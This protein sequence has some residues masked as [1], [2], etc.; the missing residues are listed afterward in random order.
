MK[1]VVTIGLVCLGVL[2]PA[3]P[4]KFTISA[5]PKP[6]Q[7]VHYTATQELALEVTPDVPSDVPAGSASLLPTMKV[8]G[9]TN[10]AF[11]QTSGTPDPQGRTTALLTYEQ[12]SGEMSV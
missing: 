1:S 2:Q 10:F 7:T 3:Q 9:K 6:G 11:T 4:E 12:A 8:A 5:A